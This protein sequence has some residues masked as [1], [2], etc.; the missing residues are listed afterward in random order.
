MCND[1]IENASKSLR[2]RPVEETSRLESDIVER[3]GKM[4]RPLPRPDHIVIEAVAGELR[5][6]T[7]KIQALDRFLKSDP[8]LSEPSKDLLK[9]QLKAMKGY[10]KVLCLRIKTFAV[11]IQG[12]MEESSDS[13]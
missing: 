7:N 4:A 5:E 3:M 9:S 11:A 10:A 12:D 2:L 8:D 13:E 1:G 6:L